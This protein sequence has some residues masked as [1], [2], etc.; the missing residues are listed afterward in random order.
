MY[1][2]IIQHHKTNA[3]NSRIVGRE[4]GGCFAFRVSTETFFSIFFM[5]KRKWQCTHESDQRA[6]TFFLIGLVSRRHRS[7]PTS[8]FV[9]KTPLRTIVQ[10]HLL[11]VDQPR[12]R[13]PQG[14]L[15]RDHMNLVT[16]CQMGS[17]AMEPW[18]TKELND[19]MSQE[20]K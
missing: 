15:G 17:R 16:S 6:T 1:V 3:L 19:S 20:S 7:Y 9:S 2:C 14:F 10:A 12:S 18:H 5:S 13:T 11:N 8:A 4:R